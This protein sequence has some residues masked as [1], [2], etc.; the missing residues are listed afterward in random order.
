M[1][2]LVIKIAHTSHLDLYWL[3]AQ[4]DCL[5]RGG[6]IILDALNFC[7]KDPEFHFTIESVR[8][9]E[10][11]L[12]TYPERKGDLLR[13][14]KA[15][16]IE[17]SACYTDRHEHYHDGEA[18][19][20]NVLYGK[21]LMKKLLGVETRFTTHP[22][23]PGFTAQTP[24]INKKAGVPFYITS[25]GFR[26]GARFKW[27][28]LDGSTVIFYGPPC[29]YG[30]YSFD[31]SV[32]PYIDEIQKETGMK[33]FLLYCSA[34]D[35]GDAGTFMHKVGDTHERV[36]LRDF[37][38]YIKSKYGIE[39]QLVNTYETLSA[40][41]NENLPERRGEGP[42]RW[43]S[44][45]TSANVL[46]MQ[47]DKTASAKLC[48][49][50][51]YLAVTEL[52]GIEVDDNEEIFTEI[53]EAFRLR[54]RRR[55]FDLKENPSNAREWLEFGWRLMLT[56][57]DHNYGGHEGY[58]SEFDRFLYRGT[59]AN[60]AGKIINICLDA[61]G[62]RIPASTSSECV[63]FNPLNWKRAE[64]VQVDSSLIEED[65]DYVA[66]DEGGSP[67]P[68]AI[69][70]DKYVF[71]AADVPSFGYKAYKIIASEKRVTGP[72]ST[73]CC[74]DGKIR[75]RNNYYDLS[76]DCASGILEEI[77]DRETGLILRGAFLNM[78]AYFDPYTGV[79]EKS[80]DWKQL[81]TSVNHVHSV[82][83]TVNNTYMTVILIKTE[84]LKAT[85]EINV[86]IH[87][88]EKK[89]DIKPT[90][91]WYGKKQVKICIALPSMPTL[92]N[93][94]YGVPYGAEKYGNLLAEPLYFG[95]D[96]ICDELYRRYREIHYWMTM[97]GADLG[98]F[99]ATL[100]GA[101]DFR[102]DGVY[103]LLVRD[104]NSGGDR[105]FYNKNDGVLTWNFSLTTYRG[106]WESL[107]LY[108]KAWEML[109]PLTVRIL[110]KQSVARPLP[111]RESF[112]DTGEVGVV[113]VFK[114]SDFRDGDYTLRL[115]NLCS[116]KKDFK[117]DGALGGGLWEC[118]N[119]DETNCE[120]PL[121]K[122]GS[123]EIKTLVCT[124]K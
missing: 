49:A 42:S 68:I 51:K 59:A 18:L 4:A 7:L 80:A 31:E 62:R 69:C 112:L 17:L 66:V 57:H 34:G 124:A 29:G 104:V 55:Y 47:L 45:L 111:S 89:I 91:Y 30:Y 114:G 20:R 76:V 26:R 25:R 22:D 65:K 122:L 40:L 117:L 5:E 58:Q 118:R 77:N 99:Y 44:N 9:L 54:N 14:V 63:V 74:G 36:T 120:D 38:N 73:L 71:M 52:M 98:L 109:H 37:R 113:T 3:G 53:S 78:S 21:R 101:I 92:S 86:E 102:H 64:L 123:F 88:S 116:I 46:L 50:E 35:G 13:M 67:S 82:S 41:D 15:G 87:H 33:D 103:A 48:D 2:D 19:V 93:I 106:D 10:Y 56:T 108:R 81:D 95:N 90:L 72:T 28:A 16:Q 60:T 75:V 115:V 1:K 94:H 105:Q 6:K 61:I 43:G 100:Q 11:F 70:G 23:L 97:E 107:H 8:F 27:V 83:V 110:A 121:D 119:L 85:L 24:Q 32:V 84:L 79:D 96:E 39:T 12:A